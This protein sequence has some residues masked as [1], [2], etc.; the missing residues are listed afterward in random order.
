MRAELR[1]GQWNRDEAGL[2]R[3]ENPDDVFEALRSEDRPAI[4]RRSAG[5]QFR[6]NDLR[7]PVDLK[8]RQCLG[9]A[10]RIQFVIDERVRAR[11][12]L[13]PGP[14]AQYCGNGGFAHRHRDTTPLDLEPRTRT[15]RAL[16]MQ[17]INPGIALL[18]PKPK[19]VTRDKH[20]LPLPASLLGPQVRY[21]D[22][23]WFRP[24][25]GRGDEVTGLP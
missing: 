9:I 3:A 25:D 5:R 21:D 16:L 6:G 1:R 18:G 12:R 20:R 15:T 7:A 4:T 10:G 13:L 22:H 14:F 17:E 19:N 24:A 23:A 11:I 8:P 2:H